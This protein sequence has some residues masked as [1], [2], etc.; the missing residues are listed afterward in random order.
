MKNILFPT[1]FSETAN[2][3]FN[4][5]LKFATIFN[6]DIIV[7]HVYDLPIIE[8]PV[9]PE[10]TKE[11]FDVVAQNQENKFKDEIK[12]LQKIADK[13][14]PEVKKLN[15]IL[16]NGDLI[17]NINKVCNDKNVDLIIMGTT[18][19]SGVREIFL[20][21]NTATVIAN[22]KA[23]VLGVP[24]AAEFHHQIKNI[25]F[26]TQYKDE[27]N[28]A[29]RQLLKLANKIKANVY[30]LH[31]QNNDDPADI[32]QKLNEWKMLYKDEK[33]DFF[34]ITGNDVEQTILN[35][36]D[37]QHIDMVAMLK[38]KR[39]FFESLFHTSITRKMAYH[40]KTPIIVYK[41]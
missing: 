10:A 32:E 8:T 12:K 6:A 3:A 40:T 26:T 13:R 41:C 17:Y 24:V 30:C 25:V 4:Y 39:S 23:T 19:A 29:L 35:F 9:L 37:N 5:A 2:A 33:I 34:S 21:S 22:A 27:D 31:V 36:I 7:L 15:S 11:V 38:H 28:K 20:G 14:N 1:D 18:G 16:L